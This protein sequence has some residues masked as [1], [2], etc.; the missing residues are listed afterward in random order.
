MLVPLMPEV[1]AIVGQ[2]GVGVG[3][4]GHLAGGGLSGLKRDRILSLTACQVRTHSPRAL[5]HSGRPRAIIPAQP[6]Q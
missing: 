5:Y 2:L 6:H 1:G 3:V 4:H